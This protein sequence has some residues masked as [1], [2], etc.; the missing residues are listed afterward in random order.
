LKPQRNHYKDDFFCEDECPPAA[1]PRKI[2]GAIA[3][4]VQ[5]PSHQIFQRRPVADGSSPGNPQ[6]LP[7][8]MVQQHKGFFVEICSYIKHIFIIFYRI[9][10][11]IQNKVFLPSLLICYGMK[12]CRISITF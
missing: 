12:I 4:G 10:R 9:I 7:S 3:E 8:V 6:Q 1:S 5:L 2:L 11:T